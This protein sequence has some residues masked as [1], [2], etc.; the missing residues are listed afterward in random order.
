MRS[1][2]DS[3]IIVCCHALEYGIL[4]AIRNWSL[5]ALKLIFVYNA[6]DGLIHGMLDSIHKTLS[7]KTYACDL[8][9]LTYGAVSMKK[10]WRDWLKSHPM[11]TQFFHRADFKAAWPE[12]NVA[13]PVVMKEIDGE[14]QFVVP[15]QDFKTM[16][17]VNDL[18][19]TINAR[20]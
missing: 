13:L 5:T 14:L 18:I 8:C 7:P 9:A 4:N 2:R 3:A 11:E 1:I 15:A 19:T 17:T 12:V 6:E 20:I 10:T 16:K